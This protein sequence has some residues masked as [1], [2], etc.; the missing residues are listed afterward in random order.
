MHLEIR[1]WTPVG[2]RDL[3]IPNL[4]HLEIRFWTPV[5][6]RDLEIPNLAHLEIR[7]LV[8]FFFVFQ[9]LARFL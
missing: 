1:L 2:V 4:A 8:I 9:Y 3:E 5:G 7:V 6:M